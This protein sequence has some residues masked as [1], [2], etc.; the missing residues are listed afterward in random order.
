MI[1]YLAS[2]ICIITYIKWD[3]YSKLHI[4]NKNSFKKYLHCRGGGGEEETEKTGRKKK[5]A[6]KNGKNKQHPSQQYSSN[7]IIQL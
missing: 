2:G 7:S 6:N 3:H 1:S 5:P 4:F